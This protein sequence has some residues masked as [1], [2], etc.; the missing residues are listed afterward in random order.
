MRVFK[1]NVKWKLPLPASVELMVE[2][3][4]R[5][6]RIVGSNPGAGMSPGRR[7][8]KW[9]LQIPGQVVFVNPDGWCELGVPWVLTSKLG[10]RLLR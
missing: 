8:F 3:R 9:G 7:D 10:D 6:T 1:E 5:N 2:R 4:P